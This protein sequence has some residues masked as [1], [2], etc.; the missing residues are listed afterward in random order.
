MG[1]DIHL[2]LEKQVK[3]K[4]ERYKHDSEIDPSERNYDVFAFL[5]GVRGVIIPKS[6]NRIGDRGIPEDTSYKENRCLSDPNA[7]YTYIG[8]HSFT[9][10]TV[11]E[12]KKLPWSKQDDYIRRSAFCRWL[13]D[14]FPDGKN[15]SVRV[16]I[17]FDS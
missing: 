17:G 16:L 1:C 2:Y 4:W 14:A 7:V 3:G 15:D 9:H 12:L 13:Y 5:C 11:K 10:A 8:D 6:Y